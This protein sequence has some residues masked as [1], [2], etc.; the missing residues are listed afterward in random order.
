MKSFK[1][2]LFNDLYH[3]QYYIIAMVSQ[4]LKFVA[5]IAE[6]GTLL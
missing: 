5:Q 3:Y 4:Y 1:Y 2:A 6:N